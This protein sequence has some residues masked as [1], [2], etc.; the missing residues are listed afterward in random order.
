[1]EE[2]RMKKMPLALLIFLLAVQTLQ[3]TPKV[4]ATTDKD[5]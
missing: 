2:E 1:M 3:G 5:L 4:G